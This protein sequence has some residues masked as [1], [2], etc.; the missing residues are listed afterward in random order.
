M[1]GA[2]HGYRAALARHPLTPGLISSLPGTAG[3]PPFIFFL[4]SY[5]ELGLPCYGPAMAGHITWRIG[6]ERKA[7]AAHSSRQYHPQPP[8]CDGTNDTRAV[9]SRG[10]AD[11]LECPVLRPASF[12]GTDHFGRYATIQRWTGLHVYAWNLYR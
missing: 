10:R 8:S 2:S 12:N 1:A 7:L 4:T 6:N 5:P 3:L 9:H 11:V